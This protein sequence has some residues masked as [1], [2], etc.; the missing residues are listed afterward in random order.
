MR[1][2]AGRG[3]LL[4]MS[5]GKE[6]LTALTILEQ[7]DG[8]GLFFLQYDDP[9]WHH[10]ARCHDRLQEEHPVLRTGFHRYKSLDL[11]NKYQ[12]SDYYG[13]VIGH[14]IFNAMLYS[15]RYRYLAIGNEYSA[16]VIRLHPISNPLRR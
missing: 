1:P 10:M 14:L 11:I 6:S 2:V 13:F 4:A 12:S 7:T 8:L 16:S 15:D 5:G 3:T 9:I